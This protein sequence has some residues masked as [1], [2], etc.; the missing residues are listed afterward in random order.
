[1]LIQI[2][3]SLWRVSSNVVL[4]QNLLRNDAGFRVNLQHA[5]KVA[6]LMQVTYRRLKKVRKLANKLSYCM[7]VASKISKK[8]VLRH[9]KNTASINRHFIAFRWYTPSYGP[10]LCSNLFPL[11]LQGLRCSSPSL[12]S[13]TA[14]QRCW[15]T[16]TDLILTRTSMASSSTFTLWVQEY[17]HWLGDS[18][19]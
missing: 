8:Q 18:V 5:W 3:E 13:L 9:K 17:K 7:S 16:W 12:I 6:H 10:A 19:Q 2:C 14:T 11:V 4:K 1:M 15:T